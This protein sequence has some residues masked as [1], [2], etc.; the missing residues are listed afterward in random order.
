MLKESSCLVFEDNVNPR[1]MKN[2]RDSS[3]LFPRNIYPLVLST[4]FSR[5]VAPFGSCERFRNIC[6]ADYVFPVKL[7]LI[8][9]TDF[10]LGQQILEEQNYLATNPDGKKDFQ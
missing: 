2:A 1:S 4:A 6:Q 7:K 3:F 9:V 10:A 8:R 5:A